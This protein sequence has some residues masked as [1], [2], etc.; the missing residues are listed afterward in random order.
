[1][2]RN[3]VICCDGTSNQFTGDIT[4]VMRLVKV[5]IHDPERQLVY[6]DPGVGTLPEPSIWSRI[7][8]SLWKA[9]DLA[10]AVGLTRKVENAYTYLMD[11]WEPRDR[12]FLFGFSRGA[13]TVRLLAGMLH[14]VGLL[15]RG[16][17]NLV[18]Y[19]L[20]LFGGLRK[21]LNSE[22]NKGNNLYWQDCNSFR[23]TFAT[24][25]KGPRNRRFPI[26]YLGVWDTVK[27]VG[28]V[29]DPATYPFT[30]RNPSINRI[31]HAV[32]IDERRWFFRQNLMFPKPLTQDLE[33]RWFP[34]SHGDIGGGYAKEEGDAW[35][36]AF[37][38]IVNEATNAGLAVNPE[39]LS[40]L[41]SPSHTPPWAERIHDS[42]TWK[43]WPA[44]LFPKL[45]P[46]KPGQKFRWPQLGLGRNRTLPV[47]AVFDHAALMRV[48]DETL[49]YAPNN[50]K[51]QL[52]EEIRRLA[53]APES[54]ADSRI[55]TSGNENSL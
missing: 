23:N 14:Q 51:E 52:L 43:W 18:P 8:Q 12:V 31:R 38:W 39:R 13:Y 32:A 5:A 53:K 47:D 55:V 6:Y 49:S 33:E 24:P 28:W 37:S 44:E 4:N 36:S 35:R 7:G 15:P 9:A 17:K 20:R 27:S 29:W 46:A 54:W 3:I 40:L 1:M 16:N 26:H 10:F 2:P 11:V 50:I 21:R 25:I 22:T 45:P 34:G 19:S 41:L 48:R 30:A 42:L